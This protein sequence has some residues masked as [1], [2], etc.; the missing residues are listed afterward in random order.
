MQ[1]H[2]LFECPGICQLV[3]TMKSS[4][5]D[6]RYTS[7]EIH[8]RSPLRLFPATAPQP[9]RVTSTLH[10]QRTQRRWRPLRRRGRWTSARNLERNIQEGTFPPSSKPSLQ[11]SCRPSQCS[12]GARASIL[13][14][15]RLRRGATT[16]PY[17]HHVATEE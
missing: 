7:L 12:R 17:S 9:W 10:A 3:N 15:T 4:I 1:Q 13:C 8:C 11:S 14:R 6:T 5:T 2:V 16:S